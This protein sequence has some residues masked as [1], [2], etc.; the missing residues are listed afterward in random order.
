M[1]VEARRGCGYRKV[2][3]LYLVSEPGGV[4]CDRLP[5]ALTVCPVCSCGIKQSR[6]FTWVNARA[7]FGGVHMECSDDTHRHWCPVCS[8]SIERAGLLWIGEKFYKTPGEFARES[9]ALGVSRR[10]AAVPRGF[11]VG[12]TWVLLAHP[13]ACLVPAERC[14]KPI[15]G[16]QN[17]CTQVEGHDEPCRCLALD[18]DTPAVKPAPGIAQVW[19]PQRL[20]KILKESA[21]D[22]KEVAEL[23]KRGITPVFVPDDDRDH[24]G[25]VHDKE[26][27]AGDLFNE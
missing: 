10:I 19:K 3:G 17:L 9:D 14:H 25:S 15:E 4:P 11:V 26:D 18:I 8:G 2:G 6:G 7:L 24:Q 27:A 20:E 12:E 21:R 1:A 16:T 5:F 23:E 22:S 13:K